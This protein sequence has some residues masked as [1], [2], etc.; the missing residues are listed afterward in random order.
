MRFKVLNLVPPLPPPLPPKKQSEP[1]RLKP[2]CGIK[3][4]QTHETQSLKPISILCNL[5]GRY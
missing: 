2:I 5:F 1:E 4:T 3:R